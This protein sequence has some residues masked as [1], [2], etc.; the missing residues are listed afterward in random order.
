M[1][2][3]TFGG[4]R[5]FPEMIKL[6]LPE[7]I[8]GLITNHG[9]DMFYVGHPGQFDAYVH[10]EFKKLKQEYSQINYAVALAYMPGKR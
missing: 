7:M 10:S 1:S 3:Y 4:L 6:R 5:D 8:I 2:A 9:V